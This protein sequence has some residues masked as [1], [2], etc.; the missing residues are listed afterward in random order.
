MKAYQKEVI[1][2]QRLAIL[3]LLHD[4]PGY[5]A[6]ASILQSGLFSIGHKASRDQVKGQLTWL[7]EQDLV[8]TE[9]VGDIM[10]ATLTERGGDVAIG[11]VSVPGVKRP[12]PK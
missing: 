2:N 5:R 8:T 3:L 11:N 6:N 1:E 4:A 9:L 7:A 10:V 12:A